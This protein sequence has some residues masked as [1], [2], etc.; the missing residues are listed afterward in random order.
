M[1]AQHCSTFNVP[2]DHP[3]LPGHFPRSPVVPGVVV[4]DRVLQAAELWRQCVLRVAGL[5]HVK[6]LAPLLPAEIADVALDLAGDALAF[7]VT[8]G[9]QVIAQGVF[10]IDTTAAR[11]SPAGSVAADGDGRT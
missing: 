10:A 3:A 9:G 11:A 1:T 5:R 7:R 2:A 8:R 4:L 6:F